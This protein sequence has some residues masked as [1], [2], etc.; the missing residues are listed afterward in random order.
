MVLLGFEGE[1]EECL[2]K[3]TRPRPLA[4]ALAIVCHAMA[5]AWSMYHAGVGVAAGERKKKERVKES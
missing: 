4:Q 5:V 3:R 1:G 2:Q